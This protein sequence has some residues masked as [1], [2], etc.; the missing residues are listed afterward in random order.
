MKKMQMEDNKKFIQMVLD[1]DQSYNVAQ[2][3]KKKQLFEKQ[4]DL[5]R[6]QRL[7]AGELVD[8][9]DGTSQSA[10]KAT[11]VGTKGMAGRRLKAMGGP[12]QIE[13][14]RMNKGLL[15]EISKMKKDQIHT[16]RGDNTSPLDFYGSVQ[17]PYDKN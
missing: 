13:E 2:K 3:E 17:A 5:Q 4:K 8:P 11:S 7:Q 10:L 14:I 1:Q 12:M 6:F 16:D 9:E 15:K